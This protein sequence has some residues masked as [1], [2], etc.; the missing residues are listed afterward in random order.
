MRS[1]RRWA[2]LR[3][4]LGSRAREMRDE[5]DEEGRRAREKKKLTGGLRMRETD[6]LRDEGDERPVS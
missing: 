1:G 3:S 5:G 6:E 4:A 2:G